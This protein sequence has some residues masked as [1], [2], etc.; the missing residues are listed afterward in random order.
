MRKYQHK[1]IILNTIHLSQI[2]LT[3]IDSSLRLADY[4]RFFLAVYL[5]KQPQKTILHL[6]EYFFLSYSKLKNY[7]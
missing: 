3:T 7:M 2:Y 1:I 6:I 5:Q 4:M